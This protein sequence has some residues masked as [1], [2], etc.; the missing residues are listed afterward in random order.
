LASRRAVAKSWS[1]I[2]VVVTSRDDR[3]EAVSGA[4]GV[5]RA[6]GPR[7]SVG[8]AEAVI[9]TDGGGAGAAEGAGAMRY[10]TTPAS[11]T[12]KR[13]RSAHEKGPVLGSAGGGA[14]GLATRGAAAGRG[15]G[16]GDLATR[17]G[18][19]VRDAG[20]VAD[21]AGEPAADRDGGAA[22]DRARSLAKTTP[23]RGHSGP[24]TFAK[25]QRGQS[26]V[27]ARVGWPAR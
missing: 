7:G 14:G 27:G 21:R 11:A 20:A 23:Q 26:I 13:S 18:T 1:G 15:G 8:G 16:A 19:A 17:G 25:P 6:I 3:S 9:E 24:S 10:P 5:G 4:C 12:S 22:A 2:T